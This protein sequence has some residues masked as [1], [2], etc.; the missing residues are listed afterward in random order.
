MAVSHW[1]TLGVLL[2]LVFQLSYSDVKQILLSGDNWMIYF[3]MHTL[4]C[5]TFLP[6]WKV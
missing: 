3:K 6:E 5:F 1:S 2:E 4:H